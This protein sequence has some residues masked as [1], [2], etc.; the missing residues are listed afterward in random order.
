MPSLITY[1]TAVSACAG[2][3]GEDNNDALQVIDFPAVVYNSKTCHKKNLGN[4]VS[5]NVGL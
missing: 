3:A 4:E 2:C 1:G 5:P